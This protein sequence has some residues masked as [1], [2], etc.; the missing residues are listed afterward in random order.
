MQLKPRAN[1]ALT[2]SV[3]RSRLE[4]AMSIL[5][6]TNWSFGVADIQADLGSLVN[7]IQDIEDDA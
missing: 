7:L 5:G 4:D 1:E 2:L 6:D 3:V